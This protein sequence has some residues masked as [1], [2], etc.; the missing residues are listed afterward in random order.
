M[1]VRQFPFRSPGRIQH[2][3]HKRECRPQDRHSSPHA[4]REEHELGLREQVVTIS[5]R[6]Y[7]IAEVRNPRSEVLLLAEDVGWKERDEEMLVK[8]IKTAGIE[9]RAYA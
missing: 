7:G 9:V 5:V 2:L 1:K 8:P 4:S 6:P 3:E